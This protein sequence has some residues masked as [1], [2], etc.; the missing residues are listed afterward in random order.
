M[1]NSFGTLYRIT[2]FGESHGEGIGVVIDGCPAGIKLDRAFIQQELDRRRPGQSR[3][4]TQRKEPDTFELLSGHVDDLTT[5]T[6]LAFWIPNRNVR[7]RDYDHLAQAYRPSH[8]DYTYQVKYGIR[9]H[10]GGGRSSARETAARVIGGAVAKL[11]LRQISDIQI[12]AWVQQIHHIQLETE[13]T[14]FELT[15]DYAFAVKCPHPPTAEKMYHFIDQIRKEG[16]SVGGVIACKATAVPPG[17]GEPIYN[18]LEAALASAMMS[19]NAVKGFEVGSGFSGTFMRGS[20]HNDLFYMEG[21]RVRTQTNYSGGIQGGIS[22]GE[23]LY[24]RVAFKPTATIMQDQPSVDEAGNPVVLKGKGR[25]DPC[26]V[27]RAVPIVE[28][29]AAIVLADFMLLQKA[30]TIN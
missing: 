27:P 8:A 30:R 21:E 6:P 17:L 5:G 18:K 1:S 29:M 20:E 12:H 22:N 3:I 19:I 7:S 25:H 26:V 2:T 24:M 11:L 23:P 28:A 9:D 4:T 15:T 14:S 13:P 16:D 10:R